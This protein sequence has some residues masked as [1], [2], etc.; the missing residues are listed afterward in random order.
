[1]SAPHRSPLF[2]AVVLAGVAL[3][4]GCGDETSSPSGTADGSAAS[5][6]DASDAT[7]AVSSAVDDGG[8]AADAASGA[9]GDGGVADA[10]NCPPG[11]DRP[12]PP[13]NLI[14]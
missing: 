4:S 14:K 13:C 11:S 8:G 12:V 7:D 9:T 3:T 10:G 5:A 6:S 2:N 1:M